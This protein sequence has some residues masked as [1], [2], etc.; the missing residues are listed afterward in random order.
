MWF[1]RKREI[2]EN[3]AEYWVPANDEKGNVIYRS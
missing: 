3:G 2:L 1:I